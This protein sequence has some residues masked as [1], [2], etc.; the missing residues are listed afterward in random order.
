MLL[1]SR[2]HCITFH[3]IIYYID[4]YMFVCFVPGYRKKKQFYRQFVY[5]IIRKIQKEN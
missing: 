2:K 1:M 4:T 5:C 3:R